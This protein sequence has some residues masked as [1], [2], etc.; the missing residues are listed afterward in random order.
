MQNDNGKHQVW[1]IS[2]VLGREPDPAS[3]KADAAA[4]SKKAAARCPRVDPAS[5]AITRARAWMSAIRNAAWAGLAVA[6]DV[7]S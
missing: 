5:D 2:C 6:T 1:Q 7:A 4:L 3:R